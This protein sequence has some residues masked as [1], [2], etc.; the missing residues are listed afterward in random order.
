[1]RAPSADEVEDDDPGGSGNTSLAQRKNDESAEQRA[2]SATDVAS[3]LKDGLCKSVLAAGGNARDAR[4]LGM[5]DGRTRADDS[6]GKK[7]QT[8]SGYDGDQDDAQSKT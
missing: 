3:H 2:D 8:E 1:M 7:Q 6:R 4:G 5:K